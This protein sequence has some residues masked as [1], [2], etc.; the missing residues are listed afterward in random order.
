MSEQKKGEAAR[1][2]WETRKAIL[3][4][5]YVPPPP[6]ARDRWNWSEDRMVRV[7]QAQEIIQDLIDYWPLTLRQI[8]YQFVGRLF[9]S[10]NRS[11]YGQLS[12]LL[13]FARIDAFLPWEVI[14]DRIRIFH[15]LQTWTFDRFINSWI[16]QFLTGYK[17]D[18]MQG[19]ENYLEIWV[20]KDALGGVM[21]RE[22][23]HYTVPVI[24]NRGNSSVTFLHN[25]QDRIIDHHPDQHPIVLYFGDFDPSGM[26]MFETP[27]TTLNSEDEMAKY[28]DQKDFHPIG[29]IE[30]KR[31]ALVYDDIARYNLPQNKIDSI[32]WTDPNAQWFVDQYGEV[33]VELD[34]MNVRDLAVRIREAIEAEIDMNLYHENQKREVAEID[35]LTELK[36]RAEEAFKNLE[37][38]QG[39]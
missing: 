1:K 31:I 27:Q 38:E 37:K 8:F 11:Q 5:T 4:G 14:E 18:L 26:R 34:A 29:G 21:M 16:E 24:I 19:Q 17:I 7:T 20:E 3:D 2:A 13:K 28:W 35:R 9:I 39:A 33:A 36:T 23:D 30:F 32:K 25:F 12:R 22:A 10:N 15:K 6:G